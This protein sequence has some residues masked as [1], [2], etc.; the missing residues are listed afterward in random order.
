MTEGTPE[1]Q[2]YETNNPDRWIQRKDSKGWRTDATYIGK[3]AQERAE[4]ALAHKREIN[5]QHEFRIAPPRKPMTYEEIVNNRFR[6]KPPP[7][8][9]SKWVMGD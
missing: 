4:A 2:T 6:E 9:D 7:R 8:S 1:L 5:P 3:G